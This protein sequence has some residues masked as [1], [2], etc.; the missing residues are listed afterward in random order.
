MPGNPIP[1]A[2]RVCTELIKCGCKSE[3]GCST[4]CKYIKA[5][6]TCTDLC[7]RRCEIEVNIIQ[8]LSY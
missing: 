3:K 7:N 4:C 5:G 2:A 1:E 6:L 8:N